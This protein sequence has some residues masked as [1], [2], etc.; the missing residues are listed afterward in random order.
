MALRRSTHYF[1]AT[2]CLAMTLAGFLVSGQ[3]RLPASMARLELRSALA[4]EL[5]LTDLCLFTEASYTRHLAVSDRYA[6]FQDYPA[7]AEHFPT[8][9]LVDPPAHLVRR[10]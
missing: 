7:A 1:G 5:E 3:L 10:R 4:R 8:G 9:A 6:P 2:G